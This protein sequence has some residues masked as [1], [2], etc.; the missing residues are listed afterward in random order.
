MQML[1]IFNFRKKS[2]SSKK[3]SHLTYKRALV[4]M[5]I[6]VV[7]FMTIVLFLSMVGSG[8]AGSDPMLDPNLNPNIK[9]QGD[10]LIS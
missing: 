3:E 8:Y 5:V 4:L 1:Y 9:V 10:H 7:G 6:M 2:S